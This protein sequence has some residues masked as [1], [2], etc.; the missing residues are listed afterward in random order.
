WVATALSAFRSRRA[1]VRC[2]L[3]VVPA[4]LPVPAV[5]VTVPGAAGHRGVASR[6]PLPG[7]ALTARCAAYP[8]Q[9]AAVD[10]LPPPAGSPEDAASS[11]RRLGRTGSTPAP[12]SPARRPGTSSRYPP[13]ATSGRGTQ[14]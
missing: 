12:A 6:L 13:C 11:S 1:T 10:T 14:R 8:P 3:P 4:A 2:L 9:E 7:P 5:S